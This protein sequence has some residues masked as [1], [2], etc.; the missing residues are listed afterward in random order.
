MKK[1]GVL[2]ARMESSF[3]EALIAPHQHA[4]RA[5]E[6]QASFV[7]LDTIHMDDLRGLTMSFI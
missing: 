3:P 7:A 1:I 2:L 5:K 4:L 6:V